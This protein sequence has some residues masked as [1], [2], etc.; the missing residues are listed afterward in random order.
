MNYLINKRFYFIKYNKITVNLGGV[1]PPS[2][3]FF[4]INE[5]NTLQLPP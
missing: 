5:N 2:T 1:A 4:L 3:N